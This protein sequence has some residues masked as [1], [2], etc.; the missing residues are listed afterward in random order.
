MTRDRV[1]V[2]L[3]APSGDEALAIARSLRGAA[4]HVKVGLTLFY[5]AGPGIV[6]TLRELGFDVFVDLK[7]HDIP[8]Q[9][10]G[11]AEALA[12]L[13]ASM[14]TVHAGGGRAMV[15]AG[16]EAL[17]RTSE[18]LGVPKPALLAVTVLTS[19]D[20]EALREIGIERSTAEAAF[21]L[22]ELARSAG[23]DGVVCSPLEAP[24]MR[25]RL[26]EDALVV[27]PGVRPGWASANDQA[28]VATPA[29]AFAA[30][31]SHIVV[32]R[33]ITA[34]PDPSEAFERLVAEL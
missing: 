2:A 21:V 29:D 31:A 24:G 27:T 32:G 14:V 16:A 30:G 18:R 13:G 33:P 9:V 10:S 4:T 15:S 3:D 11:A 34:A 23:A 25:A 5:S 17:A 1:I 26:G 22:A 6:G 8:H 19:L 7:L 20:A 12:G 28:R